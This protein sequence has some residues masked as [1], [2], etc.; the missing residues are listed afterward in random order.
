MNRREDYEQK[1]VVSRI[2]LPVGL[3]GELEAARVRLGQSVAETTVTEMYRAAIRFYLDHLSGTIND[4]RPFTDGAVPQDE[5]DRV[6]RDVSGR[7][8]G[9]VPVV[10]WALVP[11]KRRPDRIGLAIWHGGEAVH[12]VAEVVPALVPNKR[13]VGWTRLLGRAGYAVDPDRAEVRRSDGSFLVPI[14]RT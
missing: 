4:G 11:T 12:V 10:D 9:F 7:R 14:R 2:R 1:M 6:V 3:S 5:A 13:D 8:A